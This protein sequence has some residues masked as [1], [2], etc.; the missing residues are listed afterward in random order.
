MGNLTPYIQA[1]SVV[2]NAEG[3]NEPLN[4]TLYSLQTLEL[5]EY[6]DK[7]SGT[8][9]ELID[10][11]NE[12]PYRSNY[13]IGDRHGHRQGLVVVKIY[14]NDN[15]NRITINNLKK[16]G[17][18]NN[19]K[20]TTTKTIKTKK[21]HDNCLTLYDHIQIENLTDNCYVYLTEDQYEKIDKF[22]KR[23][24]TPFNGIDSELF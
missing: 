21:N 16:N 4:D 15:M 13:L 3:L 7:S 23:E 22:V 11:L 18:K 17:I 5:K 12:I 19:T 2:I 6:I 9:K 8:Y 24:I 14:E 10:L 20:K 1:R